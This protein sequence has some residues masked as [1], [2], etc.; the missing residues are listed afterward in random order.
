MRERGAFR[1]RRRRIY[2]FYI[3]SIILANVAQLVEQL[4]RNE[5]VTGSSPVVG[6]GKT[7]LKKVEEA[8]FGA[9][10]VSYRM[11]RVHNEPQQYSSHGAQTS[12][13]FADTGHFYP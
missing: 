4:T 13:S 7:L 10:F 2:Y 11:G 3:S 9:F 1:G 12:R 5:Q 8:E 6:S